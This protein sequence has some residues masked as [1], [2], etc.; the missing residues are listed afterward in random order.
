[1][2]KYFQSSLM[3]FGERYYMWFCWLVIVKSLP[4]MWNRFPQFLWLTENAFN[5]VNKFFWG[6]RQ[7]IQKGV[8]YLHVHV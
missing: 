3:Q 1:M 7:L 2:L 5:N 6:I 4:I 8:Y